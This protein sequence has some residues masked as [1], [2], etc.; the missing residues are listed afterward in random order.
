MFGF[1]TRRLPMAAGSA[2]HR[3]STEFGAKATAV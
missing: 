2:A 1:E 3:S